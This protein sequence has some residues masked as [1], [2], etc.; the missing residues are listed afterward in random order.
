MEYKGYNIVLNLFKGILTKNQFVRS[1]LCCLLKM[2]SNTI[3]NI[4]SLNS[5]LLDTK[6]K[7]LNKILL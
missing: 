6:K 7:Y 3:D 4:F 2:F 1:N 5:L